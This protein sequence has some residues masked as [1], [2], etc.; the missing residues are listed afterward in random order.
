MDRTAA[1]RTF[2][3]RPAAWKS[4]LG[5]GGE[6]AIW[7]TSTLWLPLRPDYQ[8]HDARYH[9]EPSEGEHVGRYAEVSRQLADAV[10]ASA[11]LVKRK[12]PLTIAVNG[13][14]VWAASGSN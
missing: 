8:R 6:W 9:V 13:P 1:R 10:A 5:F 14:S 12:D 11:Y 4:L 2:G 7:P 3:P